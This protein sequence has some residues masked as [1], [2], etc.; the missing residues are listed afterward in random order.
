MKIKYPVRIVLS[1]VNLLFYGFGVLYSLE[2]LLE[3]EPH[4]I[5]VACFMIVGLVCAIMI[6]CPKEQ[7]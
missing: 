2:D 5:V 6:I 4:V 1:L 7:D 3:S